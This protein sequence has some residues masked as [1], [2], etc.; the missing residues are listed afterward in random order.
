MVQHVDVRT[1]PPDLV[2]GAQTRNETQP[3]SNGYSAMFPAAASSNV[4]EHELCCTAE[5]HAVAGSTRAASDSSKQALRCTNAAPSSALRTPFDPLKSSAPALAAGD[6][7]QRLQGQCAAAPSIDP[8]TLDA[9]AQEFHTR[10]H[11][12]P[13][14]Q[15]R[16]IAPPGPQ[17][18]CPAAP[19][20][21]AASPPVPPPLLGEEAQG[22]S[23]GAASGA[24]SCCGN[25]S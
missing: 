8:H 4:A 19:A 15:R 22:V 24:G 20:P 6:N 10:V 17:L 2:G 16:H 12:I 13:C 5:V 18:G 25:A 21:P 1:Q 14:G 7:A 11:C 3:G 9:Q 23:C